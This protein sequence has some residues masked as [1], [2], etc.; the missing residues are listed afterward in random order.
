[1]F[2]W[3]AATLRPSNSATSLPAC[4]WTAV[5]QNDCHLGEF[6][7][8]CACTRAATG[9]GISHT[10]TGMLNLIS[11]TLSNNFASSQGG[12][13]FHSGTGQLNIDNTIVA[14]N[15]APTSSVDVMGALNSQGYNLIGNGTGGS[16]YSNT[17]LVGTAAMPIDP[18]LGRLDDYGGPTKTM[19]VLPRSPAL[20]AGDPGALG[21]P[22]QR[23]VVRSGGVNIGA[24][25]ASATAFQVAA[26]HSTVAGAA[27]DLKVAAFDPYSQPAIGYT[28]TV[29]FASTDPHGAVL[30][31][32]YT[33]S[34]QGMATFAG[35]SALYTSG[36]WAVS[37]RDTDDGSITGTTPVRVRPAAV[38]HFQIV[39][40]TRVAPGVAFSVTVRAVDPYGNVNPH[41]H[42]TMTWASTD[43]NPGVVLPADSSLRHRNHGQA[44][45]AGG[46]TL[47]TPGHQTLTVIDP[48]SGIR[49]SVRVTVRLPDDRPSGG[50]PLAEALAGVMA[51]APR[52]VSA[53]PPVWGSA[54]GGRLE[55]EDV[56][57]APPARR[58]GDRL[59]ASLRARPVELG[60]YNGSV[61]QNDDASLT[62]TAGAVDSIFARMNLDPA[63][64]RA[65]DGSA[66]MTPIVNWKTGPSLDPCQR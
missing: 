5:R 64:I 58:P 21:S 6:V 36:T 1:M 54:V 45:F 3:T 63:F 62:L 37:V 38:S 46:V 20:N 23:G 33:F 32:D 48:G 57:G 22:D 31:P 9:A 30:P 34:D 14:Q 18:G 44:V 35:E 66:D 8:S 2:W 29:T 25:Q 61:T 12:G 28:G 17:D 10:S 65:L 11:S 24:F 19:D 27:F 49:G 56:N 60:L 15:N 39:A 7:P 53:A 43:A 16:G 41:Y 59:V 47:I 42:G 51:D 13:I 50:S 55:S 52:S 4:L 26:P 40:P